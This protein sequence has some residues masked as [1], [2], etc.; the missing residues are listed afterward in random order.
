MDGTE[1]RSAA[2]AAEQRPRLV[3]S[4]ALGASL[5]TAAPHSAVGSPVIEH[6]DILVPIYGKWEIIKL[7]KLKKRLLRLRQ[8]R[9]INL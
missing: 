4:A 2:T 8:Y 9:L 3:Q 5:E 6:D 1:K 7:E